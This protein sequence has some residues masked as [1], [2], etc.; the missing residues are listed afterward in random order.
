[1][2]PAAISLQITNSRSV[3]LA[4]DLEPWGEHYH[5]SPGASVSVSARG[6]K[7]GLLDMEYSDAGITLWGWP[8]SVVTLSCDGRDLGS[9]ASGRFAAPGLPIIPG[10]SATELTDPDQ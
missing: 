6:P 1:M 2:L 8:G 4:F 9:G 7:G 3:D 5:I 10:A